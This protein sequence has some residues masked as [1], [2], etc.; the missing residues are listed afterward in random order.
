M[1]QKKVMVLAGSKWQ[2]PITKK[3]SEMG[4]LPYVVNL[5]VDSPAFEY[6]H[7][8]GVMD[9]L[10]KNACL[11]FA[12]DNKIDAVLS[13]ECDIAMPTVAYLGEQ[14][15][16]PTLSTDMASLYTNKFKM[17]EFCEKIGIL[18]PEYKKCYTYSAAEDFFKT[19]GK[20]II[21][22][23]LDANSSRGVHSI[24][25]TDDLK[26]YF[27]AAMEY[28]KVE[29]CIL[30]ERYIEGTEFTIDGI[31]TPE[32][33]FT[34]A[35]SEKKHYAHNPNVARELYFS[36][37]NERFDYE[38]LKRINDKFVNESGLEFGLT[39]A[40]YKYENGNFYL[41]EIAARGGGNL[42]SAEI[43]PM[44]SGIDNYEYLVECSLGNTLNKNFSISDEYKNRCC[45]LRFF[46]V[47]SGGG[48]ITAINGFE[49]L[50][51]TRNILK[52][53]LNFDVGD[54]I[55]EADDDSKRAGYYIAYADSKKELDSIISTIDNGFNILCENV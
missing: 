32:K 20:K 25:N 15:G 49:L 52:W 42:I 39:H 18:Y 29:K 5:Y 23:P 48:K 7:K 6:A 33:H 55:E 10:D 13:E 44:M 28:S 53:E 3:I 41:I 40:E 8:Y 11:E 14:L 38:E 34:M 4:H 46:D 45:V 31:K 12:R 47:P 36:H 50:N 17:R 2:I 37:S 27:S 35:I 30:A 51:R 9:I 24:T 1:E 54:I 43:A 19:L 16:V 22:K 26:K 21:I